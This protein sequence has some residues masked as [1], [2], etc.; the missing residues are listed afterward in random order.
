MAIENIEE[1]QKFTNHLLNDFKDYLPLTAVY[2][3]HVIDCYLQG[4]SNSDI[5][6]DLDS[7]A[8]KEKNNK[9][10]KYVIQYSPKDII[11]DKK[12]L[13]IYRNP[14]QK[15]LNRLKKISSIPE[16]L[17][18]I[19]YK[20]FIYAIIEKYPFPSIIGF[21]SRHWTEDLI[22]KYICLY[23]NISTD[24]SPIKLP[25]TNTIHD[26]IHYPAIQYSTPPLK[27]SYKELFSYYL[28]KST[29][30]YFVLMKKKP[31]E[32]S[33]TD[34]RHSH[35]KH[36]Y[37]ESFFAELIRLSDFSIPKKSFGSF[38]YS[39][40]AA[41]E[42]ANLV[43]CFNELYEIAVHH[44]KKFHADSNY[45][46]VFLVSKIDL[47]SEFE[48]YFEN[49]FS[50]PNYSIITFKEISFLIKVLHKLDND[51]KDSNSENEN[52]SNGYD[53]TITSSELKDSLKIIKDNFEFLSNLPLEKREDKQNYRKK[54][55][56][57]LRL[58]ENNQKKI[59]E[60]KDIIIRFANFDD[61]P[62]IKKMYENLYSEFENVDYASKKYKPLSNKYWK[63]LITKKNGY[64]LIG[65]Y[66]Q[67]REGMIVIK[68]INE[69]E[70]RLVYL[71]VNEFYR[72][73]GIGKQ[74][75]S[76]AKHIAKQL[77]YTK[78]SL[79]VLSNNKIAQSLYEGSNFKNTKIRMDCTLNEESRKTKYSS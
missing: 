68:K 30:F 19:G 54:L 41:K 72:H 5:L 74:L 76:E 18:I 16:L 10:N 62:F 78:I 7:F 69:Q 58:I 70:C 33:L 47:E 20:N 23:F 71:Y 27:F 50:L 38:S 42:E 77:G 45:T 13:E 1:F 79:Y 75:L 67:K 60:E 59:F 61:L 37:D 55:K 11:R 57:A 39:T 44:S 9:T 51:L 49:L 73:K 28:K 36:R 40:H 6:D 35:K 64:I 56:N 43:E 31:Y 24:S 29:D 4:K 65:L 2:K 48:N 22:L 21:N 53:D 46:I 32:V 3:L 17:N 63:K 52:F 34:K 12:T 25:S 26:A 15:K 66:Y 8:E 14:D